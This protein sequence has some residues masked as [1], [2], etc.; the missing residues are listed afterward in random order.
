MH[1]QAQA[2]QPDARVAWP[3]RCGSIPPLAEGFS[4][5]P[6]SAPDL[7]AALGPGAAVALVPSRTGP[8]G[9]REWSGSSGKTQLAVAAV[10]KLWGP[11]GLDLLIWITASSRSSVLSGYL[12]AGAA[13]LGGSLAG[14][15]ETAAARFVRWLGESGRRW[16]VVL[17]DLSGPAAIEGLWPDGPAGTVLVTAADRSAVRGRSRVQIA[18]I[19]AF[20]PREAVGYLTSRL[21]PDPDQRLGAVDL[22]EDLGREPLALA[23]AGAVIA[24]SAQTC[25]D[26]R[27]LFAHR[28]DELAG[29]TTGTLPPAAVTWT[30]SVDLADQLAPVTAQFMLMLCSLLDGHE[31]PG[32]LFGTRA[33]G[34]YLAAECGAQQ[35]GP[36]RI[37]E[38]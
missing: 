8:G 22:V 19:G 32:S 34:E 28:R 24:G 26:Y 21:A 20:S 18:E 6:E 2:G 12:E 14:D 30:L 11:G 9:R 7:G 10:E 27:E 31:I 36:Q 1:I 17:D 35:A 38:Y 13:V 33:I 3:V 23:Q 16:L 25:R 4:V 37:W 5:R 15:S 29:L